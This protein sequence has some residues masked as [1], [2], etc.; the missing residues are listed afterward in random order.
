LSLAN[1]SRYFPHKS[2][3]MR[4]RIAS[5][6]QLGFEPRRLRSRVLR[7]NRDFATISQ[8]IFLFIGFIPNKEVD[9]EIGYGV[10][11]KFA[12]KQRKRHARLAQLRFHSNH[13]LYMFG[14]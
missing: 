3:N 10:R 7:A 13:W 14:V 1:A 2:L 6:L 5:P 11:D 12:T 4:Q 9:W 8:Q